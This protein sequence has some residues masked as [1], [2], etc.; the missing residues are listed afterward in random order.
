MDYSWVA[1]WIVNTMLG[2]MS[3]LT[4]RLHRGW[5]GVAR[6]HLGH[7]VAIVKSCVDYDD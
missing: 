6:I 7:L 1:F 3:H 2:Q 5:S 4:S